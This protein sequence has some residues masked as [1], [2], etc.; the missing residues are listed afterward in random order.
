VQERTII[1]ALLRQIS[2]ALATGN[3]FKAAVKVR[4]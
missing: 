3:A 2:S 4:P 1:Y